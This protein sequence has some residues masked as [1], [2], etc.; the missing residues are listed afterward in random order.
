MPLSV[1]QPEEC[2]F[3]SGE[4]TDEDGII[5][6]CDNCILHSNYAQQDEDVDG[7]GDICD[8]EDEDDNNSGF[9]SDDDDNDDGEDDEDN[10]TCEDECSD[11]AMACIGNGTRTCHDY[12]GDGCTEWSSVA[13]CSY[14][15][16]CTEGFCI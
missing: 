5:D 3:D 12:D 6:E 15:E 9:S 4:D 8:Y 1:L 11:G 16:M 10:E 7:I 13:E 14:N 2:P